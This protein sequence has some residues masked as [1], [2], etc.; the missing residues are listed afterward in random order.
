MIRNIFLVILYGWL[1]FGCLSL[2]GQQ[3]T[4]LYEIWSDAE[5][6]YSGIKASQS[7]IESSEMNE[8]AIR[9]NALPQI[10][11]QLQNTYGTFEGSNGASF[12]QQGFFNV[13]GKR[14]G[15]SGSSSSANTFASIVTEYE[16]YNFGRQKAEEN[17]ASV[18]T[19]KAKTDQSSYI[20]R[21]KKMVSEKYLEVVFAAS[22]LSWARKNELRLKKIHILNSALSRS[23]LK[24]EAD[25]V[26]TYSSYLQASAVRDN[27]D[28]LLSSAGEKM[29]EFSRKDVDTTKVVSFS[30]LRPSGVF[31]GENLQNNLHPFIQM[32][33]Y[34]AEYYQKKSEIQK[35]TVMPSVKAL[36]GYSYRGSGINSDGYS[37]GNWMDGFSNPA[38]NFLVGLGLTWN[39]SSVYTNNKK[40][41]ALQ[42]ESQKF[43]HLEEQSKAAIRV[44]KDA[45]H[46]HISGQQ[47]ELVKQAKAVK[48][49]NDAYEMYFARY[50]SGLISLTELLQ[51]QQILENAERNQIN[52]AKEYWK[53]VINLAELTADFDYLF[54]NL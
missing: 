39:I 42:R 22:K 45:L 20:L 41:G 7:A 6:N 37:S 18:L 31:E 43:I 12:P 38:N 32:L 30:F 3:R 46:L 5:K 44:E 13:T 35:K 27:L 23:G 1:T 36:G 34:E 15:S 51:I 47:E 4:L 14:A 10:K 9:S 52:A 54:N 24:P 16:I 2:Y 53:Q 11:V 21:L 8:S 40:A 29:K 17:A 28:G 26:L 33:Q 50:K 49:A 48:N 19:L 25:S